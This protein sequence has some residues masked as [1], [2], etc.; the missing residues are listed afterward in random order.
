ME[1]EKLLGLQKVLVKNKKVE[2]NK[3]EDCI[4]RLKELKRY[5]LLQGLTEDM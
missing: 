5:L 3:V 2:E 4:N 1:E